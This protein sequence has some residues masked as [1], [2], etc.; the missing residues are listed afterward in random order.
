MAAI[1][2]PTI[3]TPH[4]DEDAK[5]QSDQNVQPLC[6]SSLSPRAAPV[7][8]QKTIPVRNDLVKKGWVDKKSLADPKEWKKAFIVLRFD[9]LEYYTHERLY[10]LRIPPKRKWHVAA[11]WEVRKGGKKEGRGF[12]FSVRISPEAADPQ[13][14]RSSTDGKASPSKPEDEREL[15]L[16]VETVQSMDDWVTCFVDVVAKKKFQSIET[17]GTPTNFRH[18]VHIESPRVEEEKGSPLLPADWIDLLRIEGIALD[19]VKRDPKNMLAILDFA[20]KSSIPHPPPDEDTTEKL[21][22]IINANVRGDDPH[23]HFTGF[24]KVVQPISIQTTTRSMKLKKPN[25]VKF[26][27]LLKVVMAKFTF[28]NVWLTTSEL[29]SNTFPEPSA[30]TCSGCSTK[31]H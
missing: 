9:T 12:L 27:R 13:S 28:V 11:F 20:S 10:S 31:L 1:P 22:S 18:N 24:H 3:T 21:Q 16:S 30:S 26:C 8:F 19:D 29:R 25:F 15:L 7:A 4:P 5:G 17:I 14:S 6:M 2:L 23:P